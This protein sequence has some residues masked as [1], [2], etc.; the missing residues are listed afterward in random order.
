[1]SSSEGLENLRK[2]IDEIDEK[3]V[4]LVN[5]RGEY[6]LEVSKLKQENSIQIYDP[7]REKEIERKL[8]EINTGPLSVKYLIS[9]FREIISGCRA[10]QRATKLAYL[11]PEGSFSNQA[12]FH[13]F[14]GS[15]E[16]IPVGSF[17]EV[18]EEVTKKKVEY[19]ILPVENSVEGSIGS[20]LDMLL[21][22]DLK[23]SSEH[24]EKIGHFLLS[25]SDR[26][27][28]VE[29]VATHPQA[30]GQSRKWISKHLRDVEIL[31]TASTAAAAKLASEND[32]MAAIASEY[33]ASI[34]N[35]KVLQTHIEDSPQNTT[36]FIIIG[37]DESS[38]TGEDKTSIVFALNDEPGALQNSLFQPFAKANINLTKIES[39][40][41][42]ERP[43]EYVFFVDFI[44]HSEDKNIK[45]VIKEVQKNCI[46]LKVLGSYPIGSLS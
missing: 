45:K 44:G 6:A 3:I 1:M 32:K 19:G 25:K 30:L 12:A 35:L 15:T 7:A 10:L 17:E 11:G 46:F 31:E 2:E 43:W 21:V 29:I 36:R 33:A 41:S 38:P 8:K 37:Y 23:I 34:Y 20:V 39:R 5:R 18:F 13:K 24:F 16:L 26:L 4:E 28:E 22:W 40:P 42:K 27:D 14:G 9:I